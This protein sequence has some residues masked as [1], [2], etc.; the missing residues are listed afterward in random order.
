MSVTR[1]WSGVVESRLVT[2]TRCRRSNWVNWKGEERSCEGEEGPGGLGACLA[3]AWP[4]LQEGKTAAQGEIFLR[5]CKESVAS[6]VE[7]D[8]VFDSIRISRVGRGVWLRMGLGRCCDQVG[9]RLHSHSAVRV[10]VRCSAVADGGAGRGRSKERGVVLLL[11]V[12]L[13]KRRGDAG[14]LRLRVCGFWGLGCAVQCSAGAAQRS[15]RNT[16]AGA[17]AGPEIELMQRSLVMLFMG[18]MGD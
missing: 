14:L 4:G 9:G 3:S 15:A 12:L 10:R 16:Q 8:E 13:T 7:N 6:S 11:V 1:L 17:P 5:W 18:W 2:V